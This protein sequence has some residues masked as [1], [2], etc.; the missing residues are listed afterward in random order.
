M[1][2][3][4]E[5]T[6]A[7]L[8]ATQRARTAYLQVQDAEQRIQATEAAIG[9]ACEALRIEQEKQ[10]YGRSTIENLL[11]AQAALLT[12]EATYYRA[13]ADYTTSRA[14]LKRETGL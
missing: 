1:E 10:Q 7:Q 5:L 2:R 4:Q 8:D 11:D 12:A 3:R 9:Y 13:L 6:Q 14:A